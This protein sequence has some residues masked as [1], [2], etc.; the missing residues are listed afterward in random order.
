[1][2]A[3]HRRIGFGKGMYDRFFEKE[4]KNIN[5]V[6]FVARQLCY[7]GEIVTDHHDVTADMIIVP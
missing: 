1:M 6:V 3:V 2:D 5:K 7:S 4:I